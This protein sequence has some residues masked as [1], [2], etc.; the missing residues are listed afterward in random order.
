MHLRTYSLKDLE[1]VETALSFKTSISSAV[2]L[3][4]SFT[5][6]YSFFGS[7]GFGII[8]KRDLD[9]LE[10]GKLFILRI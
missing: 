6:L 1:P 10:R 5:P 7:G 3:I 2:N 4:W 9:T 8:E